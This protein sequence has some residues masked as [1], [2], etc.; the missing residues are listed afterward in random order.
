[1]GDSVF[2][3]DSSKFHVLIFHHMTIL[4]LGTHTTHTLQTSMPHPLQSEQETAPNHDDNLDQ[5]DDYNESEDEDYDPTKPK[6]NQYQND[7]DDD[8]DDDD[9]DD[10]DDKND[11]Y[12][13]E[14]DRDLEKK[15]NSIESAQG[16]LIKTRRQRQQE[17]EESKKSKQF[18]LSTARSSSKVDVESLWELMNKKNKPASVQSKT[19]SSPSAG[20]ETNKDS[21]NSSSATPSTI[22]APT[23]TNIK[24][25]TSYRT[26]IHDG[27]VMIKR[28]YEFAGEMITEEKWPTNP[29]I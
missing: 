27:K 5:E 2:Y 6:T 22:T 17:E 23:T 8:G 9:D 11:A 3:L 24:S 25:S 12:H 19:T 1:M 28:T 26:D 20:F 15:Y 18:D 4:A 16:G 29:I 10:D 21:V 14:E 13:E 7:N